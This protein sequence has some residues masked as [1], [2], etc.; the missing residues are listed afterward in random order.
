MTFTWYKPWIIDQA[1]SHWVRLNVKKTVQWQYHV[2]PSPQN[3]VVPV[4]NHFIHIHF[5]WGVFIVNHYTS[6]YRNHN[7]K[8]H[9][10]THT[11]AIFA[12]ALS[13]RFL[14]HLLIR[15]FIWYVAIF[16]W[17]QQM[18]NELWWSLK[19]K[20]AQKVMALATDIQKF[21]WYTKISMVMKYCIRACTNQQWS[22]ILS[23]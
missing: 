19:C 15:K 7:K 2:T 5:K 1:L 8:C 17:M 16:I 10:P 4:T 14:W 20:Q 23:V 11:K 12:T 6:K 22:D 3:G 18:E 9:H 21:R 13:G